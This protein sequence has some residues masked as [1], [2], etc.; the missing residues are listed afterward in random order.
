M[1]NKC[2][3]GQQQDTDLPQ[4]PKIFVLVKGAQGLPEG[5]W[6]QGS[7]RLFYFEVSGGEAGSETLFQS[8]KKQNVVDPVWNEECELPANLPLK[9]SVFQEDSGDSKMVGSATLDLQSASADSFN[10]ELPLE[11]DGSETGGFLS[12]KARSGDDYGA[13]GSSE[14]NVSISN[15]KKKAL[16]L[17]V[18]PMDP[19]K[20]YVIGVKKNNVVDNYNKEQDEKVEAG[21]FITTVE[22]E[23]VGSGGCLGAGSGKSGSAQNASED[24]AQKL[25]KNPKQVDMVCR[26]AMKFRI[27]LTLEQD[28]GI[29]VIVP[30]KPL[31]NSLII[32]GIK[33][34]GPVFTWNSNNPDQRVEEWD[35]IIAVDGKAGKVAD[36]Q[37]AVKEA[38]KSARVIL[39]ITRPAP[40]GASADSG[41]D[42]EIAKEGGE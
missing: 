26:R 11:A 21:V 23:T 37:K 12:L 10:G 6:Q 20:L 15:Q 1:G 14:F 25:K 40:N 41:E 36:L 31:G 19:E 18:D 13:D 2:G 17:E 35:R 3:S 30:Q 7:D 38:Q 4:E 16:G 29:G 22:G 9:F 5:D 34:D 24:M 27:A 28:K 32:T 42:P 33:D 39:T 8:Q